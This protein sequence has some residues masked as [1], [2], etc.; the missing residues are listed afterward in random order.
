VKAVRLAFRDFRAW[1]SR[2]RLGFLASV[3]IIAYL[4]AC[5]SAPDPALSA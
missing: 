5:A 1:L 2:L 3:V 4:A